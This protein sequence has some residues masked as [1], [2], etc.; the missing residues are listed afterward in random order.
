VLESAGT[1]NAAWRAATPALAALAITACPA[2]REEP[3]YELKGQTAVR[4]ETHE[5]LIKHGDIRGFM[6]GMT[7][8]FKVRTNGC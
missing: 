8:P 3:S 7:M 5:V 1:C 4:A 6:P 2:G